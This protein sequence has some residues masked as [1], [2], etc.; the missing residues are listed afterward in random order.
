MVDTVRWVEIGGRITKIICFKDIVLS[1]LSLS[2]SHRY[3]TLRSIF[4]LQVFIILNL[5]LSLSIPPFAFINC[6][7]PL[8]HFRCTIIGFPTLVAEHR[9]PRFA[10]HCK[11]WRTLHYFVL[12]R[13][14][15]SEF[16]LRVV[17]STVQWTL[18]VL[19]FSNLGLQVELNVLLVNLSSDIVQRILVG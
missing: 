12:L 9:N 1:I 13:I 5:S 6:I 19:W 10:T 17:K 14:F 18:S 11:F 2:R 15:D 3:R 16:P 7:N 8:P 4:L